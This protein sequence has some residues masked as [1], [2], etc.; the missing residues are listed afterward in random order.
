M[1]GH[2][3]I[4]GAFTEM[5]KE[6]DV[7]LTFK[8][9]SRVIGDSVASERGEYVMELRAARDS[10]KRQLRH[11]LR[12]AKWRVEGAVRHRSVRRRAINSRH[13]LA[14]IEEVALWPAWGRV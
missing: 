9:V 8:M 13:E 2:D 11:H 6:G 3:A 10:S 12:E 4:R 5:R 14:T 7:R 1:I